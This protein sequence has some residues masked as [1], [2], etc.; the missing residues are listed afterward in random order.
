[1]PKEEKTV[2]L[3]DDD[4]NKISGGDGSTQNLESNI[5][6]DEVEV[7]RVRVIPS[8]QRSIPD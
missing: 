6:N 4:L 8:I 1:M 2:E 7:D 3:K 5:E